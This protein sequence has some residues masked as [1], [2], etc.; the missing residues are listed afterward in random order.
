MANAI[1]FLFFLSS[2][3]NSQLDTKHN[4]E[5][6]KEMRQ[7]DRKHMQRSKARLQRRNPELCQSLNVFS[8]GDPKAKKH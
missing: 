3:I 2:I 4:S 7:A 8:N 1:V 6:T 5:W